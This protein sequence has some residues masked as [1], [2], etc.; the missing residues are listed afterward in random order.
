MTSLAWQATAPAAPETSRTGQ[1]TDTAHA[2]YYPPVAPPPGNW[3]RAVIYCRQSKL[4][5]DGSS[6]S[7]TMQRDAGEGMCQAR[8]YN[9]VACFTDAGKSG[10]NPSVVRPGFEEM[11][12]WVREGKCDV[13]VIY[14]L[15]RLT[16]QGALEA[17]Q[18]EAE[19]RKHGVALVSVREPYLDTSD[20]VGIGIFAIIAGLAK[21]ESDGKSEYIKDTRE[22]ARKAGG[23][24]A[25]PPPFGF[26][27]EKCKT[28]EGIAWVKLVANEDERSI[29]LRMRDAALDGKTTGQIAAMLN[30]DCIPSPAQREVH[31][32]RKYKNLKSKTLAVAEHW[33]S[34]QVQRILRDP[35]IAGMAADKTGGSYNFAIRR[36]EDGQP[37]HVHDALISPAEWY[38]LQEAL[39]TSGRKLRDAPTGASHLLSGWG[40]LVCECEANH[41]A[42]GASGGKAPQYR[43]SRSAEAR[44]LMGGHRVNAVLQGA[45]DDYVAG[46]V[47]ARMLALDM[48]DEQDFALATETAR[49]FARQTDTSGRTQELK[50]WQ[51]QLAHTEESL[52]HIYEDQRQGLYAGK[53]GR[54]AF[55]EAVGAMQR[56][57]ATCREHIAALEAQETSTVVLPLDQWCEPGTDPL[58]PGSAWSRWGLAQRREFLALWLDRVIVKAAP[59]DGRRVPV[60]ERLEL[61]WATA[62]TEDGEVDEYDV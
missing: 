50:E 45:T 47:F 20:A 19:M 23:H 44:R 61:V 62:E 26:G 13:V 58:G 10:W 15:S 5:E 25:G 53:V 46:R 7:P 33:A 4:N 11:M 34:T 60:G 54:A 2:Y 22:L 14:T 48:D 42:S 24:L 27:T 12:T 30:E 17:M 3:P 8:S 51:A 29:V 35:R 41:T 1:A 59:A 37:M 49:R 9:P 18:I 21:Q 32:G 16:R 28:A 38:L 31:N 39:G 43:C 52:T 36:G 55:I 57:E 56:T 6:A 40:F